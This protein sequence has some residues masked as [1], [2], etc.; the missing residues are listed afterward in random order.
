MK[1][2]GKRARDKITGFEGII[3]G[4][5]KYLFGCRQYAI[6]PPVK[7]GELKDAQWFDEGRIEIIGN[8]FQPEDVQAE[9]PGG[10]RSGNPVLR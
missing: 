5:I 2:L 10:A 3:I 4:K 9:E 7:D 1:Y 8:V 6:A